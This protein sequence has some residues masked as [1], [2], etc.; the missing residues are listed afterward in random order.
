[1]LVVNEDAERVSDGDAQEHNI[2]A[3]RAVADAVRSTLGPKGMDKMLIDS[4]GDITV[5]N[6]GVTILEEMEIDNPTA[7]M[8]V[9]VADTQE[10]QAGDGTTTAITF[11]GELLGNAQD[12]LDQDV[13]P[14]AI[15]RGFDLAA[16]YALEEVD[17]ISIEVEPD[18][19]ETLRRIAET[20]LTG[21]GGEVN[22]ELVAELVVDAVRAVS[23][24]TD[25][26]GYFPDL[27]Y[28]NVETRTGQSAEH[29]TLL[30]GAVIDQ[31]PVHEGMP[32]EL[33]EADVLLLEEAIELNETDADAEISIEDRDQ[34]DTFLDWEEEELHGKVER[35]VEA[36]AD[37]VFCSSGIEDRAAHFLAREGVLAFDSVSE[38][39]MEAL[40]ET[41]EGRVVSDLA[42]MTA[43]DL[44]RGSVS[45]R[46]EALSFQ[47]GQFFVEGEDAHT[48]TL[49]LCG[50]TEHVVDE[51][52][53]GVNDAL[54]VVSQ[55][56]STGRVL[57][58]GGAPE[59]ELAA[60]VRDYADGVGG[61]EQL[62]VEAFADAIEVVPR[63]LAENAGLD[64]IDTLV[65]L[66]SAH[67]DGEIRAGLDVFDGEIV[68]TYD[69]GVIEPATVKR[70]AISAAVEAASLILK[71]D[72]IITGGGDDD[73]G[74]GGGAPGGGMG[75]MGGMGGGI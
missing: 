16:G 66:R 50:S 48:H 47:A 69:A 8:V 36:G 38:S 61:R 12:L 56:I 45:T 25:D 43:D 14:T 72:D 34:L 59:V 53:R 35:I 73:D 74:P 23:V 28:V 67:D 3:A 41:L 33:P 10:D 19:E 18:D 32:T 13:H 60:R 5:T 31:D 26:G 17:E 57:A 21:K 11:A 64:S 7:D 40:V 65:D 20:S 75:G 29:S 1:M 54:N 70:Q 27:E 37:V 15:I 52:E 22:K 9:E 63:T 68:D 58:G 30:S 24:E 62:A 42:S 39:D 71:I 51:F 55:A 6:D 4:I 46:N 44:R 2:R 49:L